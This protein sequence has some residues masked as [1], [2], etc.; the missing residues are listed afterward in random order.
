MKNG[1]I[2]VAMLSGLFISP[3][4]LAESLTAGR[5]QLQGE[6][7][8]A[9]CTIQSNDTDKTLRLPP[10]GVDQ[11]T[12]LAIGAIYTGVSAQANI[13]IICSGYDGNT[14]TLGFNNA[15][16]TENGVI[17]PTSGSA[18]GVGFQLAIDNKLVDAYTTTHTLKGEHGNYVLPITAYY[19][20]TSDTVN[21][22]PLSSAV[23]YTITHD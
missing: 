1:I 15:N 8:G 19:H 4:L 18:T 10:V 22:G 11:F 17:T 12:D 5:L 23:T 3:A 21:K 14:L 20:K 9:S 2:S 6:I 16:M 13:N 7:V